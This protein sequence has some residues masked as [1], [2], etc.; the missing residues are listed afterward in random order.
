MKIPIF[1][2]LRLFLYYDN[3]HLKRLTERVNSVARRDES[4]SNAMGE[5]EHWKSA[6]DD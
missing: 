4:M 6:P 1:E 2:I 3:L 5:Y